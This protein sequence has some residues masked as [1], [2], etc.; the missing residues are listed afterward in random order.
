MSVSS[1]EVGMRCGRGR[2]DSQSGFEALDIN[3]EFPSS[4]DS[5]DDGE[6][7][8]PEMV[9]DKM[10]EDW[11]GVHR[12]RYTSAQLSRVARSFARY[13]ACLLAATTV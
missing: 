11:L 4:R 8:S 2:N 6:S 9:G 1:S 12:S 3:R 10:C 7:E 5:G 13:V